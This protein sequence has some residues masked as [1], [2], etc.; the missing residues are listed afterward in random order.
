MAPAA[1]ISQSERNRGVEMAG[2]QLLLP[3]AFENRSYLM[4]THFRPAPCF[5]AL[6]QPRALRRTSGDILATCV[7]GTHVLAVRAALA[8]LLMVL[9]LPDVFQHALQVVHM[10]H[11]I[12]ELRLQALRRRL[13]ILAAQL[14]QDIFQGSCVDDVASDGRSRI[15]DV[16]CILI[17]SNCEP[18]LLSEH[19]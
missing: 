15:S 14:L 19:I 13:I 16:C 11:R 17:R 2:G 12:R 8:V 1:D 7:L 6:R 3:G 5:I 9:A 4:P 18:E 10:I